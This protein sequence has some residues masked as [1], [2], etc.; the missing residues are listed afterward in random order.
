MLLNNVI[1]EDKSLVKK[2]Y[3][4]KYYSHAQKI[5]LKNPSSFGK[6]GSLPKGITKQF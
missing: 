5:V 4:I 2:K 6:E 1:C 3:L